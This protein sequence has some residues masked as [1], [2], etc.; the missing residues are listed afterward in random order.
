[1][2]DQGK[3]SFYY[4][5]YY[6]PHFNGSDGLPIPLTAVRFIATLSHTAR[7]NYDKPVTPTFLL[8][9][10]FG[11]VRHVNT[12]AGLPEVL[13]YDVVGGIGLKGALFGKGFPRI[14]GLSSATGGG[15]SLG[16][17]PSN[18]NP[19]LLGKPTAVLT[20]A[21]VRGAHTY[22]IGGDW[23]IDALTNGNYV[24][25]IGA[26]TFSAQQTTLPSTQ[27]QALS[28]GGVGLPYASF[29][30]GAVNS[31]SISNPN[32]P[33]SRKPSLS[34]FVQD[35]WKVTRKLTLDYGL[36]WDHQGYPVEIHRRSSMFS[37][38]VANPSAGGLLGGTLYEGSGAGRCNCRFAETYPYAIGPRIGAAYQ[39]NS[40]TVF[41]A[42]WGVS[43]AQTSAGQADVPSTLGV[44]GWNTI[45]FNTQSFGDPALS[46]VN[47]LSY[48]RADLYQEAY[49]PGLRPSPGQIDTP[50]GLVDRNGGR[51]PR[52]SQWS[53]S[54]QREITRNLV[55]E[56]AYVGNRGVWFI[57]N[58][59]VD[60]N[61][62]SPERLRAFGLDI[63]SAAD[64]TVL[65]SRLDSAGAVARGFKAP[66]AGYSLANTVAQSLRPFPQFGNLSVIGRRWAR[67]GTT[68][69]RSSSPSDTRT[70]SICW[71]R[72][73]GRRS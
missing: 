9:A 4:S 49:S 35:N 32:D 58:S 39:I 69:C 47:G 45:N 27:S 25:A 33:Q 54:L 67:P 37:P 7:L 14:T 63:N 12:D 3:L 38:S 70:V 46:L 61:A 26:Y 43:Y 72:L 34:L 15:M 1:M 5:R 16:I 44:G 53:L 17:G 20:G 13:D 21:L 56:A 10:G 65:G 40:K 28:G 55:V 60:L 50:P 52:V 42:G 8:H 36:R 57:A 31:A 71:G 19:I 22:K 18:N 23:R 41:R 24:G 11:F 73:P 59:L 48:N 51:P 62:V 29:L 2:P 68:R 64:R 66:Y 6:G 30:L